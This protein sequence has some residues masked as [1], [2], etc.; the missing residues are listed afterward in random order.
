MTQIRK[1]MKNAL[2]IG[3][4]AFSISALAQKQT[5]DPSYSIHNYKHPNK[6]AFAKLNNLDKVSSFQLSTS[7]R[8]D[9]YKQPYNVKVQSSASIPVVQESKKKTNASYKHPYGL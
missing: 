1:Y 7:L 4:I 2:L 8:N 5:T 3:L 9:N 6:A